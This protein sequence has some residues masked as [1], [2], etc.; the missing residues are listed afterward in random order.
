MAVF[1]QDRNV[2]SPA[3]P[4]PL[5]IPTTW[6]KTASSERGSS[7][8]PRNGWRGINAPSVQE[9]TSDDLDTSSIASV[10]HIF[11]LSWAAALR[12]WRAGSRSSTVCL[13]YGSLGCSYIL[14]DRISARGFSTSGRKWGRP[15]PMKFLHS[16][17]IVSQ[18]H[19]N[20]WMMISDEKA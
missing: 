11:V 18:F 15:A 5:S 4:A 2:L 17:A 9:R 3:V 8:N 19:W 12:S 16:L 10:H 1:L 13:G 7:I 14:G 20:G 6:L